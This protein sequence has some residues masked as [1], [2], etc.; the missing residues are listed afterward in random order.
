MIWTPHDVK[1]RCISPAPPILQIANRRQL[2]AT[3]VR[4]P[5]GRHC[6]CAAR[7]KLLPQHRSI[8]P[9]VFHRIKI[10]RLAIERAP[11]HENIAVTVGHDGAWGI[12]AVTR[13]IVMSL[14]NEGA[15]LPRIH[16]RQ[17]QQPRRT[18]HQCCCR[19]RI[20]VPK[21]MRVRAGIVGRVDVSVVGAG[22]IKVLA[23]GGGAKH[24]E[25]RQIL[26]RAQ[27]K[28]QRKERYFSADFL[29]PESPGVPHY[30]AYKLLDV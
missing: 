7:C 30:L 18:L 16:C 14:P 21:S 8:G 11:G 19:H 13:S 9:C 22:D 4:T 15:V 26:I 3:R 12:E 24:P 10:R 17:N 25:I 27:R 28:T 23:C 20:V 6:H 2:M 1:R 29:L 5:L